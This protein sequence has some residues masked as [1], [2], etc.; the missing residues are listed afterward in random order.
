MSETRNAIRRYER[1]EVYRVALDLVTESYR[2]AKLLPKEET[3]A[4]TDQLK[5]AVTSVVLNIVE[6]T[7]RG[8]DRDFCRFARQAMGSVLEVDAISRISIKLGFWEESELT[9]QSQLT[10]SVYFKLVGLEKSLQKR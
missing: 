2:L 10:E 1:L 5:R 7:G 6:G 9:T 8:T 4:L 3:F